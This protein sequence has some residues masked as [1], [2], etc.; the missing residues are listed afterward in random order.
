MPIYIYHLIF[1]IVEI[2]AYYDTYLLCGYMEWYT[3][4]Y[5]IWL[6]IYTQKVY[7][8]RWVQNKKLI[9][10]TIPALACSFPP[11]LESSHSGCN[12]MVSLCFFSNLIDWP[13]FCFSLDHANNLI[14]HL[15]TLVIWLDP[16][17]SD[18]FG[19]SAMPK[20]LLLA[21]CFY[22]AA[23]ALEKDVES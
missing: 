23:G 18:T 8:L 6:Y 21:V 7:T 14:K 12:F 5:D 4:I 10:F 15:I 9:G 2:Y 16:M 3:V 22:S 20:A 1:W 19:F 11:E 13:C 17:R